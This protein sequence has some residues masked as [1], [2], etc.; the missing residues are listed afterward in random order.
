[1]KKRHVLLGAAIA[2]ALAFLGIG[3]T[4]DSTTVLPSN[5]EAPGVT[6]SGSGSVFGEPDV[7]LIT[8]GVDASAQSVGD[9]R[10]Q[11]AASMD[12]ML[13]ALKDGGVAENDI[14]TQRVSVQPQYDYSGNKQELIGFTVSNIVTAKVRAIDDTGDL[15]DAAVTAGGNLARV[16]SLSFTID[17]PSTLEE[18]A[19]RDAMA[20]ARAKAETL[21]DAGGVE[22]GEPISIS[23]TGGPVP[24]SF[25]AEAAFQAAD[26]STPIETG[27][28][29]VQVSVQ[30]VY[31]LQ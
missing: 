12:A 3:C 20:E 23:E 10:E 9:A 6:V 4:D 26:T 24:V 19:R 8:L 27:Q 17:D 16:E 22:L 31:G 14:Q 25:G 21:A 28:L 18:Q 15:L 30:V 1:M 13:N 2:V 7:A 5:S 29:E 11:A